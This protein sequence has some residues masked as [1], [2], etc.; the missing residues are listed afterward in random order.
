MNQEMNEFSPTIGNSPITSV[1]IN[2]HYDIIKVVFDHIV[3]VNSIKIDLGRKDGRNRNVFHCIAY[4]K[5]LSSEERLDIL[6]NYML[7]INGHMIYSAHFTGIRELFN[8]I[9]KD[10]FLPA[11][12]YLS[13]V[14]PDSQDDKIN[15]RAF[16]LLCEHTDFEKALTDNKRDNFQHPLIL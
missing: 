9:D 2:G 15:L 12:L 8:E 7:R 4:N 10:G 11:V 3:N 6:E 1:L 5:N 16:E 13:R 14:K